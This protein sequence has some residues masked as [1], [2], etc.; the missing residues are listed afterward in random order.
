[1]IK[2]NKGFVIWEDTYI[3]KILYKYNLETY[4]EFEL[5]IK[6]KAILPIDSLNFEE[7]IE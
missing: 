7:I 3:N 4:D 5:L 6:S 2:I 1:M